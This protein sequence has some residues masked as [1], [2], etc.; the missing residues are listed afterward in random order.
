MAPGSLGEVG[1]GG[2]FD[3][4]L[5]SL[6]GFWTELWVSSL[7]WMRRNPTHG[8]SQDASLLAQ[9]R[10]RSPWCFSWREVAFLLPYFTSG[11]CP[12]VL[13]LLFVQMLSHPPAANIGQALQW[14]WHDPIADSSGGDGPG[15]CWTLLDVLKPSS[16]Q[17][18]LFL[19]LSWWSGKWFLQGQYS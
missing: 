1:I 14:W 9:H 4:F 2:S 3:T 10:T 6:R 12:K 7:P 11:H 5:Y 17:L 13:A 8:W 16:L 15:A 19:I 18:N